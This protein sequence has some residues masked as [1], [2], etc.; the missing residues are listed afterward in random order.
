MSRWAISILFLSAASLRSYA[1]QE[2]EKDGG[3]KQE[4][5]PKQEENGKKETDPKKRRKE[6]EKHV[7][8]QIQLFQK[9]WNKPNA[10]HDEAFA[11]LKGEDGKLL[12]HE[13]VFEE[14]SK[15]W[16]QG[17]GTAEKVVELV[18]EV[19]HPKGADLL[20]SIVRKYKT[21]PGFM[22]KM[23]PLMEKYRWNS[24]YK[25]MGEW[26]EEETF[27]KAGSGVGSGQSRVTGR[28]MQTAEKIGAW[29]MA[30][31][32]IQTLIKMDEILQG[33]GNDT[34]S[35]RKFREGIEKAVLACTG[36]KPQKS[37]KEYLKRWKED[38]AKLEEQTM[39]YFWC[40]VSGKRFDRRFKD[41]PK[42]SY[43]RTKTDDGELAHPDRKSAE[44]MEHPL[45]FQT[46]K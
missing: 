4:E 14:L 16:Q 5:T 28:A 32:L 3:A 40:P 8:K 13:L 44:K 42:K 23:V 37:G 22:E 19:E 33:S 11:L 36:M 45:V 39:L 6:F 31:H 30:E 35:N 20:A 27:Q 1:L 41:N 25:A 34:E 9:A 17:T 21:D 10:N 24:F 46:T 38:K 2:D 26:I 43:C 12:R 29:V 15:V 18:K 7:K